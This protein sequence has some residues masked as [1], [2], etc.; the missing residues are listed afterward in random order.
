M[1]PDLTQLLQQREAVLQHMQAIDRLRRG[2]LSQ[3]FFKASSPKATAPHGPYYVL[4]GFFHG[5]K[6]S[7]RIPPDHAAQVQQDVDNYRRFQTLAEEF[8]TVSEQITCLQAQ[9]QDSKKNSSRRRSPRN[10]SKKPTPS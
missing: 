10:S 1:K 2:T 6:F 8:V 5:K 3:Q 9:P 4:Q 7:R